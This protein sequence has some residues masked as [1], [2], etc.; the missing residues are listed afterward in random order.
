MIKLINELEKELTEDFSKIDETSFLNQKKIL[1]AMQTV[2][3]SDSDFAWNT[4]YGY[5]DSGRE[6]T[7]SIFAHCFGMEDALVRPAI[8]SGTHALSIMILGLV[9]RGDIFI[10][11]TG[12]PYDTLNATIDEL[13]SV[14]V[15]Y[16][17]IPLKNE[18]IDTSALIRQIE[19][20]ASY[21]NNYIYIQRSAGYDWRSSLSV[22]EINNVRKIINRKCLLLLDNCYGEFTEESEPD[23]DIMAGSLIKNPGGGIALAGGYIA[24]K[25]ELIERVSYRMNAP[26]IGRHVGSMFGQTR[27]ILQGLFIAPSI[28]SGAL[29]GAKLC[30][31]V[32]AKMG[33]NV[34]PKPN[35]NIPS[36]IQA[37]KL[38]SAEEVIAFCEAV[39]ASSPVNSHFTPIPSEIPGY[40]DPVIMAAGA[41]VQG[42]SI[43]L[44]ADAPIREPYIVYYQGGLTYD[45]AK[46][47]IENSAKQICGLR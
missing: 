42:S 46:I 6:K 41:F 12:S 11:I 15:D 1:S 29:K 10:S 43:E 4:G 2:K 47:A 30:A 34:N 23:V 9:K 44:S 7:E 40:T 38:N 26:G 18:R 31:K 32:F 21:N 27:G 24:G 16:V 28:V 39:Q 20:S 35:S 25:K 3:L 8:A 37:I 22:S 14:G 5:D 45:H 36:I 33:Y 17:E 19:N 13:K